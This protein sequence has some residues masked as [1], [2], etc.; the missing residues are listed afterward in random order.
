MSLNHTHTDNR[1]KNI[2]IVIFLNI[3]FTIIEVV[4]GIWT[5]SLAILSDALHDFGDSIALVISLVA[6]KKAKKIPDSKKTYGYGRYSLFSALFMGGVLVAG[7]LLILSETIPRLLKP[8]HTNATGMLLIAVVGIVANGI[9][10]LRLKQGQSQNEKI[11]SWHLMEDVLGWVVIFIGS[12]IMYFWNN[13]IIDPIMT[14]GFTV[15]ILWG[16]FKNLKGTFNLFMQGVPENV[17][18]ETIK[19][20]LLKVHGIKDVHDIHVWSLDGE[21]NIFSGHI[22]VE[23]NS[24]KRF[25]EIK[26]EVKNILEKNNI[27]HST[28]EL[29]YGGFC[30]GA[31]CSATASIF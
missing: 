8:E 10:M 1:E 3:A 29:E 28:L 20:S 18:I 19:E 16:V 22:I 25:N 2:K 12:T 24:L 30:S 6:E 7:S 5:N 27:G 14:V 9:G 13:S 15:F 31:N 26:K 17:D 4:G 21:K 23:E 11:L